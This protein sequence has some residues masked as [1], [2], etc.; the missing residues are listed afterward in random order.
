MEGIKALLL[1]G[2]IFAILAALHSWDYWEM[3]Q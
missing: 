1:A 2:A 3:M